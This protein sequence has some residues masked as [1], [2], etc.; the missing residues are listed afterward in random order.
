MYCSTK[1][2][3]PFILGSKTQDINEFKNVIN[4]NLVE[5]YLNKINLNNKDFVYINAGMI[6]SLPGNP[7]VFELQQS[8]DITYRIYDYDRLDINC[9]KRDIHIKESLDTIKFNLKA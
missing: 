9:K 2:Y 3:E 1:F 8:S 5:N 4:T 7:M 6:H